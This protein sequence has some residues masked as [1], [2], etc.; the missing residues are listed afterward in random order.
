MTGWS[1]YWLLWVFG[2]FLIPEIIAL[3]RKQT[4]DTLSEQIWAWLRVTPGKTPMKT[5]LSSWRSFVMA[6]GL[7]WLA[8]H[9]LFGWWT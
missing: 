5:A 9:F 7:V 3:I 2:G 4:G 8:G 1:Y 6:C